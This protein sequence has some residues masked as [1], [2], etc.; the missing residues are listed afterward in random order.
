MNLKAINVKV[1]VIIALLFMVI[2]SSCGGN[3]TEVGSESL[4]SG[5]ASKTWKADRELNAAGDKD[6]LTKDEK[7]ETMQ[8]YADGRFAL[9]GGGTLQTG[10]WSF[11]QAGKRLTLNFENQD[12]AETFDVTKLTEDVM[13]LKANDGSE[14][15]L[16][17]D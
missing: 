6:K 15:R 16:K 17:A 12:M 9:G 10:T 3:E 1:Q 13:V 5:S 2:V 11:D 14:M 7:S 4:I 8:F